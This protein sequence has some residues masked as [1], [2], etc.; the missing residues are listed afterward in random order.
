MK[1][2]VGAAL[3]VVAV[4]VAWFVWHR[5]AR[6]N[7]DRAE[8]GTGSGVIVAGRGPASAALPASIAGR[9]VTPAGAGI[10]GAVISLTKAEFDFGAGATREPWI[11][12]T[13]AN[14]AWMIAKLPPGRYTA[15]AHARGFVPGHT[16][17]L[18]IASGEQRSG[19]VI[20]LA[21][22]GTILSGTVSDVGG[23]PIA[24]A[25]IAIHPETGSPLALESYVAIADKDGHY[26]VAL[27]D[28]EYGVVADHDDYTSRSED[29]EIMGSPVTQNFV[30]TP[31]GVIRGVVIARD[32]NKPVAGAVVTADVRHDNDKRALQPTDANGAFTIRGLHPGA[33]QITAGGRGYASAQ[34]T[35]V[36]VGIG[37]Q[38]E[39]VRVIVDKAYTISGTVVKRGT[40]DGIPNLGVGAFAMSAKSS[41]H[42]AN[43]P[44]DDQ[45]RWE[46]YGV[47]PG[48][49][50]LYAFGEA[51]VPNIGTS[52]TVGTKDLGDVELEI[53]AG[54]TIAGKVTPQQAAVVTIELAAEIGIANMFDAIKTFMVHGDADPAT[55]AFTLHNVPTGAFKLVA[56]ATA[57]PV[58]KLPITITAADQRDV[59]VP[60]EVRASLSGKVIDTTGAAIAGA[61]VSAKRTD[62]DHEPMGMFMGSGRGGATSRA[63]GTFKL[64]SL[65]A[66]E[67]EVHASRRGD[68]VDRM[69]KKVVTYKLALGDD[70][71]GVVV[72]LPAEN[73]VIR[74]Q[75]QDSNNQP[76]ADAWV[77]A[78]RMPTLP[79]LPASLAGKTEGMADEMNNSEW[80]TSSEPVLTGADG[81]FTIG[82]LGDGQYLVVAEGPRGSSRAEKKAKPGEVVTLQLAALGTLTGH[83]TS[84]GSPVVGYSIECKGPAGNVDR[85]SAASDGAYSLEH[86]APGAY[87]C[88]VDAE[89]G[90]A[91]GRIEVP[92]G[93]TT[94]ELA[95]TPW[96]TLTGQ[97]VNMFDHT[98]LANIAVVASS[99]NANMGAYMVDAMAGNSPKSDASGHFQINKVSVGK[100]QLLVLDS[101]GFKPLATKDYEVANG[102]R[103][104]LGVIE[105]VPPRTGDA[106]TFG[107]SSEAGKDGITVTQLKDGGPAA[108]AGIVVGDVIT[109]LG[110]QTIRDKPLV[111]NYLSSGS[112]G[113]GVTVQLGLARGTTVAVTSV[114]W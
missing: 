62:D 101:T 89:A 7:V 33:V 72:T 102:Q 26:E 2:L 63:D 24:E 51:V 74:G 109:S 52:V 29:V 80:W 91:V 42:N 45:G 46:I 18:V 88:H 10:A 48:T 47:R 20:T 82:K 4:V 12:T 87:A 15:N 5:H 30:L 56:R 35:T 96:S 53:E 83:V 55:G 65:E 99:S 103:L 105:I 25:H 1:K 19:V 93:P 14:G 86:L 44:S 8:S 9:V 11:A 41:Q 95:L 100:G 92:A 23:G 84:A 79:A 73:G 50:T 85:S 31:G 27:A 66:G 17:K 32:T 38:V 77:T 90:T 16:D 110:G 13:D 40:K 28:G 67:Y 114:K 112:I 106:G 36:E 71:T 59:V 64:L 98:V 61:T 68:D 113:V 108:A 6:L 37:E 111:M 94:L 21:A 58:G 57:G 69:V 76:V 49:F 81:K 60:L 39:N 34:P 75:V 22:G 70:K 54:V 43:A 3:V 78:R 104:D 97:I 107:M